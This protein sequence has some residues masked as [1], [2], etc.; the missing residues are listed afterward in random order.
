LRGVHPSTSYPFRPDALAE[1]KD[2]HWGQVRSGDIDPVYPFMRAY[3]RVCGLSDEQAASLTLIYVAVY[4]VGTALR[5]WLPTRSLD[6]EFP[7]SV[8][9]GVERR[10]HRSPLALRAHMASL[11]LQ[12]N[13]HGGCHRWLTTAPDWPAMM[14]RASRVHGNGRWAAY[15]TTELAQKVHRARYAAPDAGH[16]NSSGPRLALR[17]LG[18]P[19]PGDNSPATIAYLNGATTALA[20]LIG[21]P[22]LAQVETSLCDWRSHRYGRHPMGHDIELLWRQARGLPGV[23]QAWEASGLCLIS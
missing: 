7:Q 22:D 13:L 20:E 11:T 17:M 21:E 9:T 18:V 19:D 4:H 15:K 6:V 8:P 16:E 1:Y 23:N 5:A 3:A 12:A 2:W 10:G 14:A